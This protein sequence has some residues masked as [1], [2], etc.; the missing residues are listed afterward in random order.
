MTNCFIA[1]NSSNVPILR[2][3]ILVITVLF[4]LFS[5]SQSDCNGDVEGSA[6]IDD[7]ENCVGGNTGNEP[8]I[9]FSPE[10]SI[11]IGQPN[12]NQLVD[13]NFT[14]YQ[15]ANEPDI[16][17]NLITSDE[18]DFAISSLS[19]NQQVGFGNV[20]FGGGSNSPSFD[21]LVDFIVSSNQASLKAIAQDGEILGT[22][23]IKNTIPGIE[24]LSI[25]PSDGN[26]VT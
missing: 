5:F 16:L 14:V 25:A 21:L 19:V 18:G 20:S 9:E 13:I 7:C 12:L 6:Y 11:N 4:P 17:T 26:N 2:A 3:V 15:D 24:I 8:C 10:I 22:F 23:T 1:R